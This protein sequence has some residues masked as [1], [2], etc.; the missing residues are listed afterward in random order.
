MNRV[1]C[2]EC[3]SIHGT[4]QHITFVYRDSRAY[5]P[6]LSAF[7]SKFPNDHVR[8]HIPNPVSECLRWWQ[9]I[10]GSPCAPHSLTPRH[11]VDPDIWVDA[12]TDWGVGV[13]IGDQWAAWKL[14][15]GWNTGGRN[16]GWAESIA[17]E[18]AFLI[19][20]SRGFKDCI[21]TV[22]GDN[23]GVNGAYD[24]GRSQNVPCND[25]L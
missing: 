19:L 20:I 7:L 15:P 18:L 6:P 1:T 22:H 10:L 11:S 8:H 4:L 16:I 13:I 24:K 21:I 23:T 2:K 14:L 9:A 12:S 3:L 17:M 5:L 25:S